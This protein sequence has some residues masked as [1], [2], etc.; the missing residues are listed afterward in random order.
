MVPRACGVVPKVRK[1]LF[2]FEMENR[3]KI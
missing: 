3:I 1:E 2:E